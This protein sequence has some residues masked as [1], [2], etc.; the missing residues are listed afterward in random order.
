M[1]HM[2][3]LPSNWKARFFTIW[4]GQIFSLIGSS[5]VQF[6]LVWWLTA[7]TGSATVL[8][9]AMLIAQL[10][11]I[12]LGPVA[13]TLVDRWNRR[14][15]ML[16]ADSVVAFATLIL[17][18]LF[19]T[20]SIQIWHVYALLLVRSAGGAFHYP[21]MQ[22][23]T[24]LMVPNQYLA[25]VAGLNQALQGIVNIVGPV[26]GAGLLAVAPIQTVLLID[27]LTALIAI[28]PLLFIPVPQPV[29]KPKANG[30]KTSLLQEMGEALRYIHDWQGMKT[31]IG[32]ALLLNFLLA[33]TSSLLPLLVKAHYLGGPEQFAIVKLTF[34]VGI[35]VGGILLGVWGGFKKKIQ[36]SL[37]GV[38]GLGLSVL[39]QGA[40][41]T[42][43]F[44]GIVI[45]TF[46]GGAMNV[47]ANGPLHAILQSS[48]VP[49]MQ[50]RMMSFLGAAST[51]II[52]ISLLIGGP[53]ADTFGVQVWYLLAG[54]ICL[55]ITLFAVGNKA[56]M[57]IESGS[58]PTS[59]PELIR[60][61]PEAVPATT[62]TEVVN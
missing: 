57:Q 1:T 38:A 30:E 21:A 61:A 26:L 41:P 34:G 53:F 42:T 45:G 55:V 62:P 43:F 52:P 29:R 31:L 24:S 11:Q 37:L 13:G 40:S 46:I 6:A 7:Q 23:S 48:I 36:T 10:P 58:S 25:R 60:E 39:V 49:E 4:G 8:A 50:G 59:Q 35:V 32:M 47:I 54:S 20:G 28:T 15:V 16:V 22:A 19:A 33:P 44:A 18:T 27:V 12:L 17:I 2:T 9:L 3:A 51:A 56:L 14:R 5:L